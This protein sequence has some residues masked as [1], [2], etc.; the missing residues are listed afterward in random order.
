MMIEPNGVPTSMPQTTPTLHYTTPAPWS[1]EPVM[2]N[3][4]LGSQ[5]ALAWSQSN[6]NMQSLSAA[7]AESSRWTNTTVHPTCLI[8]N[9]YSQNDQAN[10]SAINNYANAP[11]REDAWSP[12][13]MPARK[14][15]AEGNAEIDDTQAGPGG[16]MEEEPGPNGA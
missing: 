1:E 5:Y 12:W 16:D 14:G 6:S 15:N 11:P 3:N 10:W 13:V 7:E 4:G 8:D 9:G 2:A